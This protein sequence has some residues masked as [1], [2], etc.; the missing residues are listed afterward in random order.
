MFEVDRAVIGSERR[1]GHPVNPFHMKRHGADPTHLGSNSGQPTTGIVN[2]MY[3]PPVLSYRLAHR[4]VPDGGR[5][6][7]DARGFV[8]SAANDVG[9]ELREG[10]FARGFP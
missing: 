9:F 3:R 10:T 6:P 5:Q 2:E 8:T 7:A 1:R 4:V